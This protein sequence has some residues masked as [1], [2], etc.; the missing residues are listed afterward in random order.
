MTQLLKRPYLVL[1]AKGI[2]TLEGRLVKSPTSFV[3]KVRAGDTVQFQSGNDK[4]GVSEQL[5]FLVTTRP[6]RFSCASDMINSVDLNSLVPGVPNSHAALLVYWR[7]ATARWLPRDTT[8]AVNMSDHR[9]ASILVT[10]HLEAKQDG[11]DLNRL[12]HS[13]KKMEAGLR[14]MGVRPPNYKAASM[15]AT[16]KK[17]VTTG[18]RVGM[19][20]DTAAVK[21]L[22]ESDAIGWDHWVREQPDLVYVV[23]QGEATWFHIAGMPLTT[24]TTIS[25]M[26]ARG[27]DDDALTE[28]PADLDAQLR[29]L[30]KVHSCDIYVTFM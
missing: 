7:I 5:H 12:H 13:V 14:S 26:P 3:A 28:P 10:Q 8:I 2:K 23:W 1:M 21:A 20:R 30:M 11:A 25:Q 19:L 4:D 29:G 9:K 17:V 15:L 18:S 6:K 24:A 22:S 16:L 27:A